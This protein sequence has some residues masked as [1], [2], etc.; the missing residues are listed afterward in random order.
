ME[1][2]SQIIFAQ[3]WTHPK[4]GRLLDPLWFEADADEKTLP[5]Q[6]RDLHKDQI[7]FFPIHHQ[8][9]GHWT[10]GVV[11]ITLPAVRF[12]FYDSLSDNGRATAANVRF[13]KWLKEYGPSYDMKFQKKDCAQQN[14]GISCGIFVLTQLVRLLISEDISQPIE[15]TDAR[16]R[17]LSILLEKDPSSLSSVSKCNLSVL[18]NVQKLAKKET[19]PIPSAF[20]KFVEQSLALGNLD[21]VRSRLAEAQHCAE[22]A[23]SDLQKA[24][25]AQGDADTELKMRE[26]FHRETTSTEQALCRK[27]REK[28]GSEAHNAASSPQPSNLDSRIASLQTEMSSTMR[29]KGAEEVCD[30]LSCDR[31]QKIEDA[32]RRVQSCKHQVALQLTEVKKRENEVCSLERSVRVHEL[33]IEVEDGKFTFPGY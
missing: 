16:E 33:M 8:D 17:L 28:C 3:F 24:K 7:L 10:L 12:D 31:E 22:K 19:T 21:E 18:T 20:R 14:D 27:G 2:I 4:A 23:R 30:K 25:S 13:E 5:Q 32:K 9:V 15:P 29:A 26:Q 1:F 6:L 11:D